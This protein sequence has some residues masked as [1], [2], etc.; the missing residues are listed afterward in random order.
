VRPYAK[1]PPILDRQ[2]LTFFAIGDGITGTGS[3]GDATKFDA[4]WESSAA[5]PAKDGGGH[6]ID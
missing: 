5:A 3:V 1:K 4:E 6:R 2:R